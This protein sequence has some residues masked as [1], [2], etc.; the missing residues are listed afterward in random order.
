M[1]L[2][3]VNAIITGASQGLGLEIAR[4]FVREGASVALCA[5]DPARLAEAAAALEPLVAPGR[6]VFSQPCDV[7]NPSEVA[8]FCG[9]ASAA[10]GPVRVLV[11]NAGIYG[12][13]GPV[14]SVD[15]EDWRQAIEV[16]LYGVVLFCRALVP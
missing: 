13:M 8:A 11:N 6:A 16:N 2:T 12:P 9:A 1:K 15:W 10:L 3:G 4:H 7:S 5:R 14:E